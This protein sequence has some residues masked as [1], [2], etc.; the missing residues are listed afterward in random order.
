MPNVGDSVIFTTLGG[1][2]DAPAVVMQV[3]EDDSVDLLVSV[4]DDKFVEAYVLTAAQ[5]QARIDAA[6]SAEASYAAA[7]SAYVAAVQAQID[8]AETGVPAPPPVPPEEPP[9]DSNPFPPSDPRIWR[10]VS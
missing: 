2:P 9:V 4:G 1:A 6:T 8:S 5:R 3:R 10:P 7:M